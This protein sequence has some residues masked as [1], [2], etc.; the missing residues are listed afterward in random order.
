M[1]FLIGKKVLVGVTGGIAAYKSPEIVRHLIK[2]GSEVKVIMTPS[3]KDFVT[4]LSLSTVSKNK[5]NIFRPDIF[6]Q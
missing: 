6:D 5:Q 2:K 3:S 4:P 1:S